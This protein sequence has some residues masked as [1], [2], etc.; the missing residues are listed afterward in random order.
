MGCSSSE[1]DSVKTY[2]KK[3]TTSW[4][5]IR[6]SFE[7]KR[8]KSVRPYKVIRPLKVYLFADL[9]ITISAHVVIMICHLIISLKVSIIFPTSYFIGL[10]NNHL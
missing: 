4:I 6:I 1:V 10:V 8:Y 9:E 3:V 7:F 2:V 5:F